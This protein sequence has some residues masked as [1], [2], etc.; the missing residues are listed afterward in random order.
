MAKNHHWRYADA[1]SCKVGLMRCTYCGKRITAGSF[2]YRETEEAYLPQHRAC[3]ENDPKWAE[4][5]RENKIRTTRMRDM[6]TAAKAFREQWKV[7]D[8]DDLIESL[9]AATHQ[10]QPK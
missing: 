4:L 5:D 10:E 1:A 7:D 2:R 8:L 9:T 3:S 6:L